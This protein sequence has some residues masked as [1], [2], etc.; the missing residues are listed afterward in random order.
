MK[1]CC[2]VDLVGDE[3]F[4]TLLKDVLPAFYSPL[5]AMLSKG[6]LPSLVGSISSLITAATNIAESKKSDEVCIFI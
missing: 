1:Q 5:I 3:Q 4:V 6:D 2:L